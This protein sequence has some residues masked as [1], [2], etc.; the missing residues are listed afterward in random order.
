MTKQARGYSTLFL[1]TI[2]EAELDPV[3]RQFATGC[4]SRGIPVTAVAGWHGVTRAS[5]YNWFT[6]KT[7]PRREQMLKMK[8]VVARWNRV[9]QPKPNR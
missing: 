8:K 2:D 9:R 6:G 1:S 3:V 4:I 7:S 5:V